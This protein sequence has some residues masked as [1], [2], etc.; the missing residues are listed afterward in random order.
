MIFI[1][2]ALTVYLLMRNDRFSKYG[3]V[4][5]LLSQPFWFYSVISDGAWGIFAAAILYTIFYV[6]GIYNFWIRKGKG[7]TK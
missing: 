5:G 2:G 3:A 6:L 7:K 4:A 1:L